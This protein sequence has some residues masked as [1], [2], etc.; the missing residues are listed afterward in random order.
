[1][2]KTPEFIAISP[3]TCAG[4]AWQHLS[5][6][7]F[8]A[9]ESVIPLVA[10]ELSRAIPVM[11]LAFI[12]Y[13]DAFELVA[14]TSMKPGTNWFVAPDGRWLGGYVPAAVRTYPFKLIKLQDRPESVL[15]IDEAS[16]LFVEAEQGEPFYDEDG[17]L[18][19]V[20]KELLEVLSKIEQSRAA[21]RIAVNALAAAKLMIP[22]PINVKEEEKTISVTGLNRIDEAALNALDNDTFL[23]LRRSA[24]LP[25]VYAQLFSMNQLSVLQRLLQQ[26]NALKAP[27]P[28]PPTTPPTV[29]SLKG[30]KG[31]GLSQDDGILKFS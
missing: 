22:W 7:A 14:V 29:E 15:C 16:G 9:E 13:G 17:G 5:D 31:I 24:A 28:A 27:A 20:L 21:T 4:K 6:Y 3:E 30:I 11:P 10:S 18:N 1:M 25:L 23:T 19:K 2:V 8:A 12:Q 26:Q